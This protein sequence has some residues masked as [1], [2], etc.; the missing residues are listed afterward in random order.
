MTSETAFVVESPGLLTTIQDLG[1]QRHRFAGVPPGGALDPFAAAAANLLVG[2]DPNAG[3][4]ECTVRGPVLLATIRATVAVAGGAFA[5][6][7]NERELPLWT[8]ATVE[9][10]D[11][12]DLAQRRGGRCWLAVGGG[13]AGTRWL[14][15][16]STSLLVQHGGLD[17][18]ALREGDQLA[19][20]GT[21]PATE[22]GRSLPRA[23]RPSDGPE[24][25]TV[26][27]PQFPRLAAESRK[28]LFREMFNVKHSS[29][30][31]GFR[32]SAAAPLEIGTA[33]LL[34]FGVAPGCIQVPPS[35]D[36]ILL[37]ADHQ[38]AGGYPVVAGVG[39]AW[40]PAAAQL[41]PG[42]EVRFREVSLVAAQEEW[43]RL[44][45]SLETLR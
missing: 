17:G 30:R 6:L 16:L 5:P 2:N 19:L 45:R 42:A 31:M 24:L 11:R 25:A 13:F 35:G 26:R 38:T 10:G 22:P 36:P 4:L 44:R 34:S 39:R 40:L 20:A 37:M 29:D 18:R 9:E 7:I 3:V 33:E 1:R 32:L 15:S 12:L 8:A 27:G 14:G 21:P 28:A 41:L 43:R 23:L